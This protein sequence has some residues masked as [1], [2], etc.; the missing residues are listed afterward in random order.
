MPIPQRKVR[1]RRSGEEASGLRPESC[2]LLSADDHDQPE[3]GEE[4]AVTKTSQD[5]ELS[6]L[7]EEGTLRITAS[8]PEDSDSEIVVAEIR[9]GTG[10]NAA[11]VRR[12]VHL[13]YRLQDGRWGATTSFPTIP[14]DAVEVVVRPMTDEDLGLM[15]PAV[16][17]AFL[18]RQEYTSIPVE[19]TEEGFIFP[20][21]WADQ[22]K[23]I[24]DPSIRWA[25]A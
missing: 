9:S 21:R 1:P 23:L 17:Q 3:E 8:L 4:T 25:R 2:L 5:I 20:A 15:T 11:S 22:R 12:A 6:F 18:A 19:Q 14:P 10:R 7:P 24:Q 13:D 16:V